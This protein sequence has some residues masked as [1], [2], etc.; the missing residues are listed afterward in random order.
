M[1]YGMNLHMTVT[2][3]LLS[4]SINASA[5][6]R[7]I[8]T[9]DGSIVSRERLVQ[10][11]AGSEFI[12]LGEMHDNPL[13]H[14]HRG[15]LL[16]M[17]KPWT[18]AVVAE[19][20]ERGKD[21]VNSS[22][23]Q[24]DLE[25]AGFDAKGWRWP[26]HE[27]LFS[28]V[29]ENDLPLAGGNI[30]REVARNAVRQGPTALPA[31]LNTLI[32][33]YPLEAT[34]QATLD[35]DLL[36]SHCGQ[37]PGTMLEGLRL[38]QRARDAAMFDSLQKSPNRPAILLAGNGHVRL[39]Y[40]VPSFLRQFHPESAFISIGFIESDD[41]ETLAFTDYRNQY[42]YLWVVGKT[43][44]EDPCLTFKKNDKKE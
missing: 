18:P 14:Q 16:A 11:L 41:T 3:A 8:D 22:P 4:L 44:R 21:F 30:T 33:Q 24:A 20:L 42:D 27:P 37:L 40:G 5:V 28:A 10:D 9:R 38:A 17:L 29:R 39:D 6:E 25:L 12:L 31:D 19:H 7:I 1:K 43:E 35:D 23:L 15:E 34:V 13:H 36:R 26:L 2:L 32:S